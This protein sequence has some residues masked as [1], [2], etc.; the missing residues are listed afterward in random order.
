MPRV[1]F[2]YT[3]RKYAEALVRDG[4]IRLGTLLD[5]QKV[6]R[7][8]P[9]I[10]DK[11]EGVKELT[12]DVDYATEET[13]SDFARQLIGMEGASGI[14]F[15]NM[16]FSRHITSPNCWLF[17]TSARLSAKV[18]RD[19]DPD[20]DACVRIDHVAL[21]GRIITTELL[22]QGLI[23]GY[24]SGRLVECVYRNRSMPYQEDDG[25]SPVTLK[26]PSYAEQQEVRFVF[27]P[28]TGIT[29]AAL[30]LTRSALAR[31][32]RLVEHIPVE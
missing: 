18:M 7:H 26:D 27:H 11:D 12:E 13:L 10:G 14:T 5:Y 29:V 6:E 23:A 19:M 21:F 3:K 22:R 25:L 8:A 31:C 4:Q 17:C 2:K 30:D 9:M 32:C 15:R 20:Y 24:S 1:L 28:D 16:G